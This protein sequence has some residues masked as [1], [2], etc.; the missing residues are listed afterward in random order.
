MLQHSSLEA[1]HSFSVHS[2]E[3]C[4]R[5][6]T[7]LRRWYENW[8]WMHNMTTA[9]TLM[10]CLHHYITTMH[11]QLTDNKIDHG[12]MWAYV[13]YDYTKEVSTLA[14]DQTTH[15]NDCNWNSTRNMPMMWHNQTSQFWHTSARLTVN[16]PCTLTLDNK[17]LSTWYQHKLSTKSTTASTQDVK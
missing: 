16:N 10:Q 8:N 1:S 6:N 3:S 9:N 13:G 2:D 14:V 15:D 4:I 12:K 17:L 5:I 11:D 7:H